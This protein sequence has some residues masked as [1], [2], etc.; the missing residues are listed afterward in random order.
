MFGD[1]PYLFVNSE[2]SSLVLVFD[3]SDPADPIFK[4]L[5]PAGFRPEGI[6][7]IPNRDLLVAASEGECVPPF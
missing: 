4:Q 5:L 2:R 7:A 1:T 6:K 3:I